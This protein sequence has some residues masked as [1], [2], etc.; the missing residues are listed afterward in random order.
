MSRRRGL[1]GDY[2]QVEITVMSGG[3]RFDSV[4]I[5]KER[6]ARKAGP[7]PPETIRNVARILWASHVDKCLGQH[8]VEPATHPGISPVAPIGMTRGNL[9][10]ACRRREVAAPEADFAANVGA[11]EPSWIWRVRIVRKMVIGENDRSLE[12]SLC[13]EQLAT[14]LQVKRRGW[15]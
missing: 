15:P 14:R 10:D 11:H 7:H 1:R 4:C 13:D 3:Q 8:R 2:R 12:V 6:R 9:E 5:A